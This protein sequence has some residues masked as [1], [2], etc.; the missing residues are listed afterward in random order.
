MRKYARFFYPAYLSGFPERFEI[1]EVYT[2]GEFF[3]LIAESV[4]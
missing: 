2:D 4:P 3:F 1:H